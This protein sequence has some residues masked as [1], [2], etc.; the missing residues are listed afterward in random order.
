MNLAV[1]LNIVL[2]PRLI[3]LLST[4]DGSLRKVILI[5]AAQLLLLFLFFEFSGLLVFL[6]SVMLAV[7]L[8]GLNFESKLSEPSVSKGIEFIVYL[9]LL[10]FF[11]SR[12]AG[13]N[14]DYGFISA[15]VQGSHYFLPLE[16][17]RKID[18]SKAAIII[19]GILIL[20]NEVNY[21]I[22]LLFNIFGLLNKDDSEE[23]VKED[24]L[25]AGR[26]IGLFERL[27]IFLFVL[28]GEFSAI[29]LILV[30][31]GIARFEEL[32]SRK[33]AEYFLIGTLTS[34]LIS[35]A[36]AAVVKYLI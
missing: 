10:S 20:A 6:A 12:F 26:I 35:I 22:R 28:M 7:N 1:L 9:I 33:F 32:K 11:A 17:T 19:T 16:L 14:I 23:S 25:N 24:E 13:L 5:S 36:I 31:K 34:F 15:L 30:A 2:L 21:V 29:G 3:H 27:I 18:L 8:L 4:N